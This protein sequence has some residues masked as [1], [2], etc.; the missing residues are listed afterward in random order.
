MNQSQR[1]LFLSSS[2]KPIHHTPQR[3]FRLLWP[4][5][6]LL[7][8]LSLLHITRSYNTTLLLALRRCTTILR[9]F[10]FALSSI[11]F[12]TPLRR[13]VLWWRLAVIHWR[14]PSVR[15]TWLLLL[16]LL[17]VWLAVG[18]VAL[19]LC[20]EGEVVLRNLAVAFAF[21]VGYEKL[22]TRH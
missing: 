15:R 14:R 6:Q 1:A 3:R 5:R 13:I 19:W 11:G 18:I 10:H 16:L 21:R 9:H 7:W 4:G 22:F 20:V 8:R 12:R 17:W 2:S